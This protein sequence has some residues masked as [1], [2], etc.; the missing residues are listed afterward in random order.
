MNNQITKEQANQMLSYAARQLKK[1]HKSPFART[2]TIIDLHHFIKDL[3]QT[4]YYWQAQR[5][6][7][8]IHY[9]CQKPSA[10]CRES[11]LRE[12]PIQKVSEVKP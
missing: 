8:W 5:I 7:N 9:Y 4:G 3:T 10:P 11:L 1:T 2:N 12:N 6:K